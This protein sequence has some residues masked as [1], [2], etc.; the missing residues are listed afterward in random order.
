MYLLTNTTGDW[1][2]GGYGH[3]H[4]WETLEGSDSLESMSVYLLTNTTGDWHFGV[5][6]CT[7]WQTL[8]ESD[9]L[10]SVHEPFDKHYREWQFGVYAL[11]AFTIRV[12]IKTTWTLLKVS[13]RW[14]ERAI[15]YDPKL[16]S[17]YPPLVD[18]PIAVTIK[19][20]IQKPFFHIFRQ[21]G[22][23]C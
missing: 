20:K 3:L 14:M 10:E 5:C 19:R 1:Q 9:I 7:F 4:F 23:W 8:E 11:L 17:T 18:F 6:P 21:L 12:N 22:I 15:S 16:P 13:K 2:F